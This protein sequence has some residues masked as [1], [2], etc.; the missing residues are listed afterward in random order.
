MER[1]MWEIAGPTRLGKV[2]SVGGV[3]VILFAFLGLRIFSKSEIQ[4]PRSAAI[5]R[6]IGGDGV[7]VAALF[8]EQAELFDTA[9]LFLPT[10][11][12][13]SGDLGD[14]LRID[15]QSAL[16]EPFPP[17]LSVDEETLNGIDAIEKS[18]VDSPRGFLEVVDW[19]FFHAF[20]ERE[21]LPRGVEERTGFL[22]IRG[23]GK[24]FLL[25]AERLPERLLREIEAPLWSPARFYLLVD[26]IG[27]VGH[28]RMAKST[29][30]QI[31]NRAL[32]NYLAEPFFAAGLKP[33]Y[34]IVD[35]GP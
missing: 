25:R 23:F 35:I 7:E 19:D 22:E 21:T 29:G 6:V 2:V 3:A 17:I 15:D 12:N 24:E 1:P 28:A 4:I 26:S 16:F 33:G 18:T 31:V 27:I 8:Q 5:A 20:G 9:P 14:I 10:A 32:Q 11:W 34:Y 30:S 13:Y